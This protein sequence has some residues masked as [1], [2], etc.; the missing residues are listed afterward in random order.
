MPM[1][2]TVYVVAVAL[3]LLFAPVASAETITMGETTVLEDGD[4]G[5]RDLLLAQQTTLTRAATLQSLSF[6]VTEAWGQLRLGVYDAS[7]PGGGPG[8]KRAETTAFT[9]SEGWNTRVVTTP[10]LLEA[11]NYWLAYL[12]S[13]NRLAFRKQPTGSARYYS[14]EFGPMPTIFSTSPPWRR[15]IGRC[16]RR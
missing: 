7:G 16:S 13:R 15:C 1:H 5:N 9:P 6:Y 12:P 11:G 10:V 3:I 8:V 4:S 14:V 2:L